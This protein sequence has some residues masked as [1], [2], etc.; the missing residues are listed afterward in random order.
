MKKAFSILVLCGIIMLMISCSKKDEYDEDDDIQYLLNPEMEE[1]IQEK[2]YSYT[3]HG[4]SSP[5]EITVAGPSNSVSKKKWN[6]IKPKFP[7]LIATEIKRNPSL[8]LYYEI[9]DFEELGLLSQKERWFIWKALGE[10]TLSD[11]QV[12][13]LE[14]VESHSNRVDCIVVVVR[15]N[16]NCKSFQYC[17]VKMGGS[18]FSFL[19]LLNR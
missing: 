18:I 15:L 7:S 12:Y 4:D 8:K 10:Y 1:E 19:K 2:K 11:N 3:Y 6:L 17:G 9:F 5:T 13:M 16:N 14:F